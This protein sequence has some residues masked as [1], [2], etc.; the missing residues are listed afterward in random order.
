MA[1]TSG[2]YGLSR[3]VSFGPAGRAGCFGACGGGKTTS[4]SQSAAFR[5]YGSTRPHSITRAGRVQRPSGAAGRPDAQRAARLV[6]FNE[7]REDQVTER[8]EL[9]CVTEEIGLADRQLIDEKVTFGFPRRV[10]LQQGQVGTAPVHRQMRE[11]GTEAVRKVAVLVGVVRQTCRFDEMFLQ[12]RE[13]RVLPQR[14]RGSG[15][16]HDATGSI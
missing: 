8:I 4:A 5:K 10:V 6:A 11:P 3:P 12:G 16:V 2:A 14:E 9:F 13:V 1:T 7:I 15:K